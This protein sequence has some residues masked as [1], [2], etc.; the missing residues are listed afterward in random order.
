MQENFK[1]SKIIKIIN[2]LSVA[3][4]ILNCYANI[5]GCCS[6]AASVGE[7]LLVALVR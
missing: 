6:S 7:P 5:W 4:N 1:T 3:D 2:F